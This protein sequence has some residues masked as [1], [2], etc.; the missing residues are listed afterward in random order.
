MSAD[1]HERLSVAYP[2][3]DISPPSVESVWQQGRRRQRRR[4]AG[5]AAA[6]LV[7]VAAGGFVV[8]SLDPPPA[9]PSVMS[10]G[11][12]EQTDEVDSTSTDTSVPE[13]AVP[14]SVAVPDDA[15]RFDLS[16]FLCDGRVCPEITFDQQEQLRDDLEAD[17]A[18]AEVFLE[19]KEQAYER[20]LALFEDQPELADA[21]DLDA[22]PASFR[23]KLHDPARVGAIAEQFASYPGVEEV[24]D[25]TSCPAA[26]CLGFVPEV[27]DPS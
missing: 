24:V 26:D 22:L 20:F 16:V 9:P 10:T 6:A 17:P 11:D 3:T 23:V 2:S 13:A 15:A 18:V 4:T 14:G 7:A 21:V 5:A 25:Q 27:A 19:S 8:A 1:L 12:A